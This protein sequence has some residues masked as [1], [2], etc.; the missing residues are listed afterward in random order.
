MKA[1]QIFL[2]YADEDAF[3]ASL[4]QSSVETLLNDL[5]V[6]VWTYKRDQAGDER[7]IGRGLRERIRESSAVIMLISQFTLASG[8]TQ[9]MELACADAFDVPT[10][11]LLHHVTFDTIKHSEKGVPPL[12]L[13]RQCTLAVDWQQLEPDLRRCCGVNTE[14]HDSDRAVSGTQ[15]GSAPEDGSQS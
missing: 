1:P 3:E 11:V 9:W 5:K 13:Q 12:L 14:S 15:T 6:R 7:N 4:L 10:F 8:A 2:S